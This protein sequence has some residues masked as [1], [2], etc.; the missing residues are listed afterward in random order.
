M[1]ILLAIA[2]FLTCWWVV[3]LFSIPRKIAVHGDIP[4]R[5]KYL[6]GPIVLATVVATLFVVALHEAISLGIIGTGTFL[7]GQ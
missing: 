4:A 1:N 2:F 5:G 3:F 6:I 7:A